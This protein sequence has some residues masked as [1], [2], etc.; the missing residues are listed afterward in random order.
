MIYTG[1]VVTLI[2][3]LI[4]TCMILTAIYTLT[5]II[6]LTNRKDDRK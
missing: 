6:C 2:A 3:V 5:L 1:N 4:T